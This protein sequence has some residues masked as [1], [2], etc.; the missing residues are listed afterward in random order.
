[1]TRSEF[2]QAYEAHEWDPY[3]PLAVLLADGTRTYIDKPEQVAPEFGEVVITRRQNPQRPERYKYADIARL[4]PLTDLPA[5]PGGMR[6]ADFDALI[7][8]L[9]MAEPFRPFAIELKDGTVLDISRRAQIGRG[10]RYLTLFGEPPHSFAQYTYDQI[11]RL[12]PHPQ[13]VPA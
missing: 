12:V 6:Y 3:Q 13:P 1:M 7:R 2:W 8:E 9:L 4:V 11:A 5:D 10:G